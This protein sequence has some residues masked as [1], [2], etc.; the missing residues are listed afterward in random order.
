M[1]LLTY[2]FLTCTLLWIKASAKCKRKVCPGK[3]Q[4]CFS[5]EPFYRIV[6]CMPVNCMAATPHQYVL[7]Y[8]MLINKLVNAHTTCHPALSL[9]Q[10]FYSITLVYDP[11]TCKQYNNN[12]HKTINMLTVACAV[13]SLSQTVDTW[14]YRQAGGK[15]PSRI[16]GY[17]YSFNTVISPLFFAVERLPN[18]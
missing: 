6:I 5:R 18:Y 17:T 10:K 3:H 11:N 16:L 9:G 4:A 8:L 13:C 14:L 12:K 7:N 1:L 2:M 15:R